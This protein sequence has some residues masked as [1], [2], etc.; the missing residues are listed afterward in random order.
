MIVD[1][2]QTWSQRADAAEAA[3]LDR[4]VRRVWGLPGTA[5][6]VIGWPAAR[7]E[8]LFLQWHYWWQAH[9]I[10]CAID[11]AG[12]RPT[13][14]RAERVQHLIRSHRMRNITAWTNNYYDDM[15]WMGLAVE[16][17]QRLELVD[18]RVA[19]TALE[20]DIYDAWAPEEGGGIPW[21]RGDDFYNTPANGPAGIFLA[22]T[23][24]LT[25]AIEMADWLDDNLRDPESGLMLDGVHYNKG[26]RSQLEDAIYT[27]CQGV[28]LG[29][30]TELAVR[31]GDP[32]HAPRVRA[33][34]DAVATHLTTDDV[35]HGR[36]GGDGGLFAGILAR[37]LAF[38]AVMLPGDEPADVAARDAAARIVLASANAAWDNSIEIEGLPLFGPDWTQPA[39]TPVL[40]SALSTFTGG[41]VRSSAIAE[42]DLSVQTSGWMVIE[43][44]YV[45][46]ASRP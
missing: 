13:P 23:G 9:V 12:R 32:R 17:A 38:V 27:Y 15:A 37:Y 39:T 10:D 28:V 31:T 35:L 19:I 1:M 29:L 11:A 5:L 21:R 7:H 26:Q 33:L 46:A 44:A 43:A 40:G 14:E 41:T 25:R 30:E 24:K 4:H 45:V 36:G 3:I 6:G 20:R 8:R 42:R 2:D 16:R 18:G 22:R 34:V